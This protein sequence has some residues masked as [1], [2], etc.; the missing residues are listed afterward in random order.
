MARAPSQWVIIN[1]SA[2]GVLCARS[3]GRRSV[4][5]AHG[6]VAVAV[7]EPRGCP[8]GGPARAG[9]A[10]RRVPG[11]GAAGWDQGP[12]CRRAADGPGAPEAAAAAHHSPTMM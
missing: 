3:R 4:R 11:P 8:G 6:G 12:V 1:E 10:G 2:G 9:A 5:A 7:R